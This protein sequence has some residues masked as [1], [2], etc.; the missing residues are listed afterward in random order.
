MFR[1][2]FFGSVAKISGRGKAAKKADPEVHGD[3]QV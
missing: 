3:A 1:A 2:K